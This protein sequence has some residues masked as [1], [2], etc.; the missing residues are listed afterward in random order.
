MKE[1]LRP[2]HHV[3]D[4]T[5]PGFVQD[6][7]KHLKRKHKGVDIFINNAGAPPPNPDLFDPAKHPKLT[8]EAIAQAELL[9]KTNNLG[10]HLICKTF[11]PLLKPNGR[12]LLFA[13]SMGHS[14]N[15]P[16]PFRKQI[17]S[18]G[19]TANTVEEIAAQW[20]HDVRKLSTADLRA[21]WGLPD[22]VSKTLQVA[23][24]RAWASQIKKEKSDRLICAICPGF[25]ITDL[26]KPWLGTDGK[27]KA[28]LPGIPSNM[29]ALQ[30]DKAASFIVRV[31]LEKD[32]D[33]LAKYHGELVQYEKVLPFS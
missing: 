17:L 33:K 16:E 19:L 1:K 26:A 27:T 24:M 22:L 4:V 12:L 9:Y 29:Q 11:V 28:G 21:K 8:P 23:S 6:F 13:S 15:I 32:V 30:P 5:R 3:L 7:A 2:L 25:T 10:Q 20:I 18:P 31:A 14:K